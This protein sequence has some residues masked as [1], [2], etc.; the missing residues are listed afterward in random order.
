MSSPKYDNVVVSL[1]S[2]IDTLMN[3]FIFNGYNALVDALTKPLAAL[4][5]LFIV[6]AGYGITQGFIKSP[7]KELYK[8]SLRLGGI[9]FFAMNWGNFSSYMVG[10]FIDG[11][12]HLGATLMKGT[13]IAGS[14]THGN[15][16]QGLQSVFTEVIKVG[17][18]TI[19]KASLRHL[20]P[21]YTALMIY[22]SGIAVVLLALFEIVVAKIMLSLC[23]C[24]APL[25][26]LFTLFEKTRSFFDRWLGFVVG[27]S[28]VLVLVSSVVGLCMSLIHWSVAGYS[29]NHAAS[30]DSVGWIPIFLI[31]ALS[32]VCITQAANIAKN[33]GGACH[34]AGGASM[35]MGLMG[36]VA[37]SA[38]ALRSVFKKE[39]TERLLPQSNPA[40]SGNLMA[41]IHNSLRGEV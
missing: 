24:T 9:Y 16:M 13:H 3:N 38:M 31:A 12:G 27:Y 17:T 10:L 36:G 39:N 41:N 32:V 5:L 2:Q 29:A 18:W 26:F 11:A 8:F 1:T 28:L 14:T 34:T 30:I 37:G 40:A 21:Y 7:L 33:I 6:L 4:S 15:I 23:L 19:K 22:I 35:A 25:F 20:G